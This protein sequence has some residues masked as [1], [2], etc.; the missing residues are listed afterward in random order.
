MRYLPVMPAMRSLRLATLCA[1]RAAI[2]AA[3]AR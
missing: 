2:P 3:Y 1:C